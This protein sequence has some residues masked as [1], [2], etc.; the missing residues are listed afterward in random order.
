MPKD[1]DFSLRLDKSVWNYKGIRPANFPEK[2]IKGISN[3]L[4]KTSNDG[5]V[6]FFVKK[7]R[8]EIHNSEILL[9]EQ[10][11]KSILKTIMNFEG[12]GI[13][14]KEEMF[15]NIIMPFLIVYSDD[16][17]MQIFLKF[18]FEN[19]PPLLEN[20]LVKS[21]KLNYP[22]VKIV[23]LKTYMGAILFQKKEENNE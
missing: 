12:I 22:Q 1:F 20:N 7:L 5:I 23:N 3:L 17:E 8:V 16:N 4:A 11:T 19:Y 21:F 15:F 6:N 14:R 9:K 13:Q 18:M 2:R 10:N